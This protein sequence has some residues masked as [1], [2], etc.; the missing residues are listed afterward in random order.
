LSLFLLAHTLQSSLN[1]VRQF[2]ELGRRHYQ[3][4]C[5]C[6]LIC[7]NVLSSFGGVRVLV[8][9]I[10]DAQFQ[11]E[12]RLPTL[13]VPE[14]EGGVFRTNSNCPCA[15]NPNFSALFVWFTFTFQLN[16]V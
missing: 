1:L 13:S 11:Q 14:Y 3:W 4:P 5:F 7:E 12:V 9:W 6:G 15:T 8:M 10:S 16:K 2:L